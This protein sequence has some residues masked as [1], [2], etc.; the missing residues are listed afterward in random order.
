MLENSAPASRKKHGTTIQPCQN[1]F[2]TLA[3]PENKDFQTQVRTQT[4]LLQASTR[5]KQKN[6][7]KMQKPKMRKFSIF[8]SKNMQEA[9]NTHWTLSKPRRARQQGCQHAGWC[10]KRG[11]PWHRRKIQE[12]RQ[13][14]R[15][16]TKERSTPEKAYRKLP[17]RNV[18]TKMERI[19]YD[20]NPLS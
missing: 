14:H 19:G 4:A 7:E 18:W 8:G 6:S 10:T 20:H 5:K 2:K 11:C 9:P 15:P 3:E 16:P 13:R 1:A 17:G 12:N